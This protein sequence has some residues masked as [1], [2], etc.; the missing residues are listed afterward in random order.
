MLAVVLSRDDD[1]AAQSG[2]GIGQA[3][4]DVPVARWS[5]HRLVDVAAQKAD[6]ADWAVTMRTRYVPDADGG[7]LTPRKSFIVLRRR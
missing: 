5:L 6:L 1:G 2:Q 7:E 4:T 3:Q